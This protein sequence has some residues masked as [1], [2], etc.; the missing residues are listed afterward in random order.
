MREHKRLQSP[1]QPLRRLHDEKPINSKFSR[2][3]KKN[4]LM[5]IRLNKH[6]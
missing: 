6:H 4:V 3:Y 1:E 5:F 2:I